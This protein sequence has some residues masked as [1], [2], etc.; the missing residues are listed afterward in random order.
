MKELSGTARNYYCTV[1]DNGALKP[2]VELVI[3]VSEPQWRIAADDIIRE[4]I[5]ETLRLS[6]NQKGVKLL[7][8]ALM[9]ADKELEKLEQRLGLAKKEADGA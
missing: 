9:E 1:D 8:Q 6:T 2:Q 3:I 5:S 7:L 4:R